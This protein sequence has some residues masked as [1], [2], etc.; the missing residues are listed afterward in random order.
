VKWLLTF[1]FLLFYSKKHEEKIES[2]LKV[3][4]KS[5]FS[6][7]FVYILQL[8][9][10]SKSNYVLQFLG[11]GFDN[12]LHF[13]LVRAFE[14]T[15]W[16]A[17]VDGQIWGST[18]SSFEKY[19]AGY[20][21]V[22]S[23]IF[24][25]FLEGNNDVRF[26]LASYF[27]VNTIIFGICV[28]LIYNLINSKSRISSIL[29]V[30]I[31]LVL[32]I[33]V[34]GILFTN[35]FVSYLLALMIILMYLQWQQ[36]S[37]SSNSNILAS[38]STFMSLYLIAPPVSVLVS[39]SVAVVFLSR[40][41][42]L[43]RGGLNIGLKDLHFF[44]YCIFFLILFVFIYVRTVN[45]YGW[46]QVNEFG[47]IQPIHFTIVALLTIA[48][49][50]IVFT[51]RSDSNFRL[52]VVSGILSM[53]VLISINLLSTG[54]VQY[55]AI[56]QSYLVSI[57]ESLYIAKYIFDKFESKRGL[58][59]FFA[60]CLIGLLTFPALYP[61]FATGFMG[62]LPN[63][64]VRT[65]NQSTWLYDYVNSNLILE[66]NSATKRDTRCL[67][68][69]YGIRDTDLNGRWINALK[70]ESGIKDVCFHFGQIAN[71][72]TLE[73]L[74]ESLKETNIP[75][76]IVVSEAQ[77]VVPSNNLRLVIVKGVY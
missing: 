13:D 60:F 7:V 63:V 61:K 23:Y 44:F 71:N 38:F 17:F 51:E 39:F 18:F 32:A 24:E 25:F 40:V 14:K 72:M 31:C 26:D 29:A 50:F 9:L 8:T 76:S 42:K 3:E 21:S 47:L 53:L 74:G 10:V 6:I 28:A 75:V 49:L 48:T 59:S 15:P 65:L 33:S 69:K 43:F 34:F 70:Q 2:S 35:G 41:K 4:F 19:P 73:R 55:Y 68:F 62:T 46:R 57:L 12:A 64:M 1:L 58:E 52:V 67:I 54:T 5:V 30:L 45:R 22:A 11:F 20:A 36:V 66:I 16:Y 27:L 77:S 37:T 56:K